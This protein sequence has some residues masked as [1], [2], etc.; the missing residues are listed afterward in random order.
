VLA[1]HKQYTDA[2]RSLYPINNGNSAPAAAAVGRYPEGESCDNQVA[3]L[4]N[5]QQMCTTAWA[6]PRAVRGKCRR[7][8]PCCR[9]LTS[10]PGS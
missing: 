4:A 1:T 3:S 9:A 10:V 5:A 7:C 2:F 8:Q 6:R